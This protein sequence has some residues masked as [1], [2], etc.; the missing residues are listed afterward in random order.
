MFGNITD[1]VT[2]FVRAEFKIIYLIFCV[3]IFKYYFATIMI[4][5]NMLGFFIII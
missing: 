3:N 5:V 4:F 1:E 2:E